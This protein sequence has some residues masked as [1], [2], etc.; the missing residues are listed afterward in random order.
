MHQRFNFK[1]QEAHPHRLSGYPPLILRRHP[2]QGET[3]P[4]DPA[5]DGD[6]VELQLFGHLIPATYPVLAIVCIKYGARY[7]DLCRY[8]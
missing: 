5:L 6:V 7:F 4:F 3:V 8:L 2:G 1:L